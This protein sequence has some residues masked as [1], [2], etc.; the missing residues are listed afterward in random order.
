MIGSNDCG[1]TRCQRDAEEQ[2][3]SERREAL[4]LRIMAK[5]SG[6]DRSAF[7]NQLNQGFLLIEDDQV[8]AR[9]PR[10]AA[11][12]RPESRQCSFAFVPW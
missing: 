1:S 4:R 7:E 11:S 8:T 10:S 3:E 6:S 9:H 5:F 2:L 12:G